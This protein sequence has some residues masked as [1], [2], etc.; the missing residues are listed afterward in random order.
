VTAAGWRLTTESFTLLMHALDGD[1]DRAAERYEILRHRLIVFFDVR[2]AA[3][4]EDLA[5]DVLDRVCRRLEEGEPIR[6]VTQYSYGVAS[7]VLREE[8]REERRRLPVIPPPEDGDEKERRDRC[9]TACLETLGP[10]LRALMLRYYAGS[11]RV[12]SA[13]RDHMAAELGVSVSGL[14]TKMHRLRERLQQQLEQCVNARR[15]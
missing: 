10:E 14:R 5:D 7:R 4:S 11:G 13:D 2:G 9:L 15:G 8:W 3:A 1:A 12:R 6:N